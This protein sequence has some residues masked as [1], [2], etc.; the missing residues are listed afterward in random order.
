L[1][2]GLARIETMP[3]R[4]LN[5][6]VVVFLLTLSIPASWTQLTRQPLLTNWQ[7]SFSGYRVVNRYGLFRSMT[8]TRP[9][10]RIEASSNGQDWDPI[11]FFYKPG[12][13]DRRPAFCLPNMPRLD[14]QMWFDGLYTEFE[15][16]HQVRT[17]RT[18][19]P[20]LIQAIGQQ[21][22]PVLALL[23]ST[24]FTDA[25]PPRFLRWHLDQYQF[26]DRAQ[27]YGGGDWWTSER[28]YTS[29]VIAAPR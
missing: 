23:E 19:L 28:V 20:D 18:I 4:W 9:E 15:I 10:L 16:E 8:T 26:T 27:R 11:E 5:T 22:G 24:P 21:R 13:L 14:W 3:R 25:H 29:P 2:T 17:G 1:R 12:P 7:E 6:A